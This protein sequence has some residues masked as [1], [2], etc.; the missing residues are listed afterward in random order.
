MEKALEQMKKLD[1]VADSNTVEYKDGFQIEIGN[2]IYLTH[3]TTSQGIKTV[4]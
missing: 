3:V 1:C 4:Y 2:G